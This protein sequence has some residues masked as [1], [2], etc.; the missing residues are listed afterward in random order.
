MV[1]WLGERH[2]NRFNYATQCANKLSLSKREVNDDCP[3]IF[4]RDNDHSNF[5]RMGSAHKRLTTMKCPYIL[6]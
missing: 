4:S 6:A 3:Y 5:D 1:M 2:K